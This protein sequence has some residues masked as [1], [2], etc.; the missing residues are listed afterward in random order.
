GAKKIDGARTN[1]AQVSA[2][3]KVWPNAKIQIC[4]WHLKKAIKKRLTDNTY[5]KVI[6]YSSYSAHQVF[7]F[8]DIEFYPTPPSQMTPVQ[9]KSFCFCPKELRPKILDMIVQH[10]HFHSLIPNTSGVYLTAYEIWKQSTKQVYEFC[11]YHDLKLL[12]IY[13]WEHWY[14]EELWVL[15]S[16]S[17]YDKICLFRTTMLCESHWK[18]IKQDFLPKFFRP[19]LDLLTYMGALQ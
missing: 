13:L 7:E 3:Q 19:R 1:F 17:A 6:N 11:T 9:K 2:A 14:R 12:W 5:P 4:F 10:M 16:H 15:W 18:V 8:I